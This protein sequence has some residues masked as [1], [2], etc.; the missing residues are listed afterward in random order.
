[1][2]CHIVRVIVTIIVTVSV[3]KASMRIPILLLHVEFVNENITAGRGTSLNSWSS[4]E[5]RDL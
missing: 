2:L 5:L 4:L 1:M 3:L